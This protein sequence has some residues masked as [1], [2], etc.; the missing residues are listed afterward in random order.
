[1]EAMTIE[2]PPHDCEPRICAE[3][4]DLAELL[5]DR[6]TDNDLNIRDVA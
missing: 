4:Y 6:M 1:M 5:S 3:A 2:R